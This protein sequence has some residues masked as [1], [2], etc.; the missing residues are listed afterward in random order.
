[1][2]I[3]RLREA[4]ERNGAS[5]HELIR[6]IIAEAIEHEAARNTDAQLQRLLE[7]PNPPRCREDVVALARVAA[8]T[9]GR[10]RL[11]Q[12][13]AARVIAAVLQAAEEVS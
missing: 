1:M 2:S 7:I 13:A 12:E 10:G 11:H 9:A 5:P 4:V 8:F 3:Y 6:R